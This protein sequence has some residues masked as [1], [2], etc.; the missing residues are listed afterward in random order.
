MFLN[1]FIKTKD[2]LT[3]YEPPCTS[4]T[5]ENK[6]LD[7]AIPHLYRKVLSTRFLLNVFV[8][9]TEYRTLLVCLDYSIYHGKLLLLLGIFQTRRFTGA[10]TV[11][12]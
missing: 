4:F 2:F 10:A 12:H 8:S 9:S 7:V 3:Y 5:R 6:E 11:L 1:C